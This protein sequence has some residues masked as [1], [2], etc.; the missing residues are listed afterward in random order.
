MG[1]AGEA[2]G[3]TSWHPDMARKPMFTQVARRHSSKKLINSARQ[4]DVR[5][6][7]G[8]GPGGHT[9]HDRPKARKQ[10]GVCTEPRQ[11]GAPNQL[12]GRGR[13]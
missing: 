3:S 8:F 13:V 10:V 11:T 1:Q 4:K 2:L 6:R 5:R 7:R 9:A 12:T